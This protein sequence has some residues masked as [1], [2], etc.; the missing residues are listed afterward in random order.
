MDLRVMD[1]R[2]SGQKRESKQRDPSTGGEADKPDRCA[3]D[4][5]RSRVPRM[6]YNTKPDPKPF[7]LETD[8][9]SRSATPGLVTSSGAGSGQCSKSVVTEK[10][11]DAVSRR[12]TPRLE[13]R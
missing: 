8:G 6:P 1:R 12:S 2:V 13:T 9:R 11:A 10:K 3:R 4:L 5:E 7:V